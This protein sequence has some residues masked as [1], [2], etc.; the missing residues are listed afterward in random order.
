MLSHIYVRMPI[1]IEG[2]RIN[3][4]AAWL[5]HKK[6]KRELILTSRLVRG[7]HPEYRK[8]CTELKQKIELNKCLAQAK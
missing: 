4:R 7:G 6:L 1:Y 3:D 5:E 8:E 2:K